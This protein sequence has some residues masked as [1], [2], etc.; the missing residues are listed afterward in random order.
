MTS[1]DAAR[2][3]LREHGAESIEHPG[4]TLY[5]HLCRVEQR[6]T[7]CGA[8]AHVRLAGLTHAAYSTDG[9]DLALISWTDRQRLQAVIGPEAEELVYLYGACDRNR[10]WPDLVGTS[11]VH[12]RFTGQEWLLGPDGIGPF[13]DLSI[14]NELDVIEQNP[15]LLVKHGDYFRDLFARWASATSPEVAAEVR[16]LIG[17]R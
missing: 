1:D 16:L 14:V 6:L 12:D 10:T 2:A 13:V 11:V 17:S 5:S 4:G 8:A 3:F 7:A 9:F 15:G